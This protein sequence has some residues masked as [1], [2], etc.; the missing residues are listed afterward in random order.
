MSSTNTTTI[1]IRT[2]KNIKQRAQKFFEMHGITLSSAVNLFLSDVA[3]N[4]HVSFSFGENPITLYEVDY[5]DLS[6]N[7]KERYDRV[8]VL[9]ETSFISYTAE[10]VSDI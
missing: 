7:E 8:N 2:K 4:Q 3:T 6:R 10:N 5:D 9:P 1:T